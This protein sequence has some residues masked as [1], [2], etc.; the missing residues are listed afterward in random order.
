IVDITNDLKIKIQAILANNSI[1]TSEIYGIPVIDLPINNK[2]ETIEH[3][4]LILEEPVRSGIKVENAGDIIIT[5]FVSDN[6][7]IIAGGNIHIYG[8]GRGRL[9]A[10]NTG[11][12]EARIFVTS[13][14]A[15]LISI[16][17]L[18]RVIEEK[19]PANI[20]HKSVMIYLDSKN[21]II[22]E[23]LT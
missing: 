11:N 10:G 15:E 9:I 22:I 1:T 8:E 20:M 18:Y 4:S 6:A 5:K 12:K 17:G 7:E 13:F 3:K 14:N 2:L 19:L 21:R 16:G 23:P